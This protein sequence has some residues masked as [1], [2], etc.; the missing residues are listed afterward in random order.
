MPLTVCEY[1]NLS[2]PSRDVCQGP[3]SER[4]GADPSP[5]DSSNWKRISSRTEPG[6]LRMWPTKVALRSAGSDPVLHAFR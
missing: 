6:T 2:T 5:V 3:R 4:I 1:V